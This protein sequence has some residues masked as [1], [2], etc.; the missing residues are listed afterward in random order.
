MA[1]T[2]RAKRFNYFGKEGLGGGLNVA[3][4][5]LIISPAEMTK[6]ENIAITQSLARRKRPGQSA[7]HTGSYAGTGNYPVIGAGNPI[8]GILQYWRSLSSTGQIVEDVFLHQN[9]KV[10]SIENR[11]S[12]AIDRTGALTLSTSAVPNY[13]VFEGILYFTS[14]DT[15]DGYNKWNGLALVP[16]PA[17]AATPPPDGAGKYLGV[18]RGRM[19]MAGNPD[20]PFRVYIS[21]VLDGDLWAGP[22][23][24]SFDLD[25]DGD[26]EGVTSIFPELDGFLYISTRRS[27]YQLSCTDAGD[28]TTYAL[29]RVSHGIGCCANG[30]VV[31]VPNDVMFVSDRGAHSLKRLEISNNVHATYLSKDIQPIFTN[32]LATQLL[33][34]IQGTWDETQNLYLLS[35]PSSGQTL[36]DVVL[37]FNIDYGYWTTWMGIDARSINTVLLNNKQYVIAGKENGKINILDPGITTDE[38]IGFT[39]AFKTGKIFPGG[40]ISKNWHFKSITILASCTTVTNVQLNWTIEGH[41]QTISSG[42]A[43]SLGQTGDLLGSTFV[44]GASRLGIGRFLPQTVTVG[45]TGFNIQLEIVSGGSSDIE[46]Y[47]FILEVD[48]ADPIYT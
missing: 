21:A 5:P 31:P 16:G 42:K 41:D 38:G 45:A 28:V 2:S 1:D 13:Q 9:A 33:N 14:T 15:A 25:Y 26:P 11:T 4:N 40:D 29:Q 48:D 6:A 18:Y 3:D 24:T 27:I 44:L 35:C 20:F 34:Q 8:R 7:Y 30:S 32:S 19:V 36:N 37:A 46:F 47:G 17:T 10:W 22:D 43:F 12:P 39:A 23:T